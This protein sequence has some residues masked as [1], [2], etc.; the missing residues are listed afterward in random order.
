[1]D[2]VVPRLTGRQHRESGKR[3]TCCLLGNRLSEVY[4]ISYF[5]DLDRK[6]NNTRCILDSDDF[7][8]KHLEDAEGVGFSSTG[9]RGRTVHQSIGGTFLILEIRHV[10]AGTVQERLTWWELD[11]GL[12][13]HFWAV[14][15]KNNSE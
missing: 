10:D 11:F 13:G 5:C 9:R 12:S 7:G 15:R 3:R 14:W 4:I 6:K 2:L 8:E 1:M